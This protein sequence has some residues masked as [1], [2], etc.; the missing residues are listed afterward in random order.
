MTMTNMLIII[1]WTLTVASLMIKGILFVTFRYILPE[2]KIKVSPVSFQELLVAL[3]A[4]IQTELDLW[5]RNVFENKGAITNSNFE[6]YYNEI[7]IQITKSLSPTF[8][9]N[10]GKYISE[11][12]VISI[13]GRKTREYLTS[14]I[15]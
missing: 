9:L 4:A 3:N 11:D 14:K 7:S 6:N 13:I 1:T 8:Y 2:Y 5:E 12:A 15:I 10:I